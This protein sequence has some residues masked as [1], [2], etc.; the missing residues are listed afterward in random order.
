VLARRDPVPGG[1]RA[2][3][4]FF[5]GGNNPCQVTDKFEVTAS[6]S[7][8]RAF[9]T[10]PDVNVVCVNGVMPGVR[11][12]V[13]VTAPSG[14]VVRSWTRMPGAGDRLTAF[15]MRSLPGEVGDHVIRAVQ[16]PRSIRKVVELRRA[17]SP[18]L[19]PLVEN[20]GNAFPP[21]SPRGT[22]FR[23][24]VGGF[25]PGSKV[26]LRIYGGAYP[27]A[28]GAPMRYLTSHPVR[29]DSTGYGTW[30]LTTSAGD[31]VGCY[32]VT[33]ESLPEHRAESFCLSPS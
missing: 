9:M 12:H 7:L 13:S 5:Q 22:T 17:E 21:R 4:R 29:V 10:V 6:G 27:S 26:P 28:M 24:A 3:L 1:V 16:G 2:Q 31:P 14:R 25:P 8:S 18:Q 15:S 11:L 20:E 32:Y 19:L 23:L 33:H 30:E